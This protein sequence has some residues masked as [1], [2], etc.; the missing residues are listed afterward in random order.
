VAIFICLLKYLDLTFV[1]IRPK[2]EIYFVNL[3]EGRRDE[4]QQSIV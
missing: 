3:P 4:K 2:S 1:K